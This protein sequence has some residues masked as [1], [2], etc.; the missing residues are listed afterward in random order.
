MDCILDHSIVL[1]FSFLMLIILLKIYK[2]MPLKYLG[3]K[4]LISAT[5]FQ[6]AQQNKRLRGIMCILLY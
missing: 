1:I 2:R 3:E 6:M 4:F 5:Y